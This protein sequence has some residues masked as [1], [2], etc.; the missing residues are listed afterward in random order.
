MSGLPNHSPKVYPL[1]PPCHSSGLWGHE[2]YCFQCCPYRLQLTCFVFRV[3]KHVT[4]ALCKRT[5]W[6]WEPHAQRAHMFVAHRE[7]TCSTVDKWWK[8]AIEHT[9]I[10]SEL[11]SYEFSSTIRKLVPCFLFNI[12]LAA[13]WAFRDASGLLLLF[14]KGYPYCSCHVPYG[15]C[16]DQSESVN[17]KVHKWVSIKPGGDQLE[18]ELLIE[19]MGRAWEKE[20][21]RG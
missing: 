14:Q 9:W 13:T 5:R 6:T 1:E 11:I 3:D 2:R 21:I 16:R 15:R 8:W 17:N 10:A 19:S 4:V 12:L 20:N 7:L 18:R